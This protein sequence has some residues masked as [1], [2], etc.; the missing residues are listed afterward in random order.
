MC[1]KIFDPIVNR[2]YYT[3]HDL[4]TFLVRWIENASPSRVLEPSCGDGV[5]LDV[6]GKRNFSSPVLGFE[7]DEVEAKKA[8]DR[9]VSV[10]LSNVDIQA[11]DF[12]GQPR[13]WKIE[14]PEVCSRA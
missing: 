1:L 9:A 10:G 7:L 5:F 11:S 6:L 2:V 13:C 8:K 14:D 4:A 3:P 12:L